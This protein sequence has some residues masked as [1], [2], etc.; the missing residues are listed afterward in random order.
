MKEID[1][2]EELHEIR[3]AICKEAGGTPAAY[4]RYYYEMSQRRIAA[5]NAT[6][7]NDKKALTKPTERTPARTHGKRPRKAVAS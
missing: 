4:A 2:V 7:P 6:T 5:A 1:P 3:R